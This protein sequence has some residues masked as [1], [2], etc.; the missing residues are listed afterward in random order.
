MRILAFNAAHDGSVCSLHNGKIEFFCKEERLVK[1]KRASD[2]FKS[3]ELYNSLNFGKINHILYHTPSN[4][5][6]GKEELYRV[7]I[8]R[9][10][11]IEME[12]YSAL[13]HHKC[14]AA[15]AYYNSGFKNALVF[16]VDRNGSIFFI[17]NKEVARESESVFICNQDIKP[18][19][20]N[21]W[22]DP[23]QEMNRQQILDKITAYYRDCKIDV[24]SN[25]GI[26]NVYEAATTLIGQNSLENG[27]TMGL[28][29]YGKHVDK[30][31]LFINGSPITN[32]FIHLNDG[33][34]N[35]LNGLPHGDQTTCFYKEKSRITKQITT[36]N[37]PYYADKAK[38][39]QIETQREVGNL[40]KE[41]VK[42]T[43]INNIC[44]AGGYGLNVVANQYYL[45]TIPDVNFYFEP[46]ADDTG[47]S[48]GAAMLKWKE[49]TKT[50]P[51]PVKN[52]FY[53]YYK[54][55]KIKIPG[56]KTTI[57]EVCKLLEKKKSV[58]IFDGNPEAGPR[59][60]GHRSILFD[61]RVKNGK[62]IINKIKKREWYRPFAGVIL[63]KFLYK[64]FTKLPIKESP[65][66]TV[67][68]HCKTPSLFPAIVHKDDTS[69]LQ[70]VERGELFKILSLFNKRNK[71][72]IL[73]NTSLNLAGQ[74]LVHNVN[75]AI[76]ILKNSKLDA[77]YFVQQKKLLR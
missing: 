15:L 36:N 62:D 42:E 14:H 13:S 16:V 48:V 29:A 35:F 37:Y 10:F 70:T 18:I 20:K 47:I 6:A 75:D 38:L 49:V 27:K 4:Y 68:F 61:A 56:K 32:R 21:F 60:L 55:E 65:Y 63:K 54:K 76:N 64:H 53:H 44:M 52:N 50:K 34:F 5:E 45:K 2:P 19:Y 41:Y 24:K 59:A 12:N 25:L 77:I 74:P 7:Y 31:R 9:K 40:I 23:T 30:D 66:M 26:V 69:R 22:N 71:C 58:A 51:F 67:N 46:V 33:T 57:L 39:V 11:N 3:L 17:N 8:H 28:S 43:G 72:P 73:L 1:I